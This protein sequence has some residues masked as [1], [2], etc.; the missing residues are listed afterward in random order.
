MEYLL[1]N[2]SEQ[3]EGLIVER[4]AV[5]QARIDRFT[6]LKIGQVKITLGELFEHRLFEPQAHPLSRYNQT[7]SLQEGKT[8]LAGASPVCDLVLASSR[9]AWHTLEI[10][11][12]GE[13]WQIKALHARQ[14]LSRQAGESLRVGPYL[15]HFSKDNE[16]NV[17][18]IVNESLQLRHVYTRIPGKAHQHSLHDVSLSIRSGE[19]VGIIGPSGAGKSTL[20]KAIRGLIPLH[21]GEMSLAN[22]N[23][24]QYPQLRGELGLVPQDDVV[25][26]EL[27]VSENLAFAARLRLPADWTAEARQNKVDELLEA[28]Q[29]QRQANQ[30]CTQISGG[31]RKR[32][33]L[34][35]ELMLEPTFL[36]A[37]E[38]CS[39]L[40]ALDSDN[41]LQ[42]LR[43]LAEQGKG[44]LLTIHSPDIE[45]LDLMDRLLV[46]DTGGYIA[47]YGPP[48]EALGYFSRSRMQHGAH[49]R[50]PKLIF[51]VLE[52][53][54]PNS[55]ERLV[56]PPEQHE[57]FKG[58]PY[59]QRYIAAPLEENQ[60]VG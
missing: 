4:Q 22:R 39:G 46:L 9:L 19:F 52:K 35:L 2:L 24:T 3:A 60:H 33:N 13:Q 25:I 5:S 50:S 34:A 30:L 23:F 11:C 20:L 37:D 8:Y 26:P 32:V 7:Y 10:V 17:E 59:Y 15:L 44:V 49:S 1:I 43:R 57:H 48:L 56:S 31:Q 55:D 41:I 12:H 58:S 29:L 38:V 54:Q 14:K 28:M 36:L 6:P 18:V 51:D 42:H 53:K 27:T 40:S 16:L 21:S 45:A 47:Y